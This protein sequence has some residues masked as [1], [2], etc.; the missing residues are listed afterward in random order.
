MK[1][2]L[3]IVDNRLMLLPR[4]LHRVNA[5]GSSVVPP[6]WTSCGLPLDAGAMA[7]RLLSGL[8]IVHLASELVVLVLQI[9]DLD[10]LLVVAA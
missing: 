3:C 9:V 4:D 1:S 7:K 2:A 8:G 6:P 10:L 5:L